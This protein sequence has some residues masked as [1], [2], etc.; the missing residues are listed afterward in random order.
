MQILQ[1]Y[2]NAYR[3][4]KVKSDI[5]RLAVRQRVLLAWPA[6]DTYRRTALRELQ[7]QWA[8]VR[9]RI[10]IGRVETTRLLVQQSLRPAPGSRLITMFRFV[11]TNQ[12]YERVFGQALR[13]MREEHAE[14]LAAKLTMLARWRAIQTNLVLLQCAIQYL[15][16]SIVKLVVSI[17]TLGR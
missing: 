9:H 1:R 11:F 3:Y 5:A 2:V 16:A 14:A 15:L 17:W 10:E 4:Q 6:E 8:D 7:A 13:D 12:S